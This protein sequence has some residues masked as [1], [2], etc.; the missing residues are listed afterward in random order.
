MDT[1]APA[2]DAEIER[3]TSH[4]FAATAWE[5]RLIARTVATMTMPLAPGSDEAGAS[6]CRCSGP[7]N[8]HGLGDWR[9]GRTYSVSVDCRLH[10]ITPTRQ[11]DLFDSARKG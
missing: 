8:H 1:T 7:A 3:N 9:D 11:M 6:G 10:W 4:P 5:G 2:T